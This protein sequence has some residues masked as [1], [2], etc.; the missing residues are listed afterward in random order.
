MHKVR[1][2]YPSESEER[3]REN[4][5]RDCERQTDKMFQQSGLGDRDTSGSIAI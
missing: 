2:W 1:L 3:E 5:E 4:H